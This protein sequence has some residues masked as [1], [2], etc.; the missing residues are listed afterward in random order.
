MHSTIPALSMTSEP[1]EDQDG[2]HG[3]LPINAT[4]TVGDY[5]HLKMH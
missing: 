3:S 1:L 4:G 2:D 5:M